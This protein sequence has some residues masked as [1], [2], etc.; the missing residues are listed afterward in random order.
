MQLKYQADCDQAL[1][2]IKYASRP[3]ELIA[4]EGVANKIRTITDEIAPNKKINTDDKID[5]Q[6]TS[7]Y[8]PDLTLIDLPGIAYSDDEGGGR[9]VAD[10]IKNL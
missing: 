4:L 5:L 8:V 6:I 3:F 2:S 7:K 1:V 10:R 9:E